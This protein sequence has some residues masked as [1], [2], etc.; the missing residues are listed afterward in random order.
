VQKEQLQN[1][2]SD[3]NREVQVPS[4]YTQINESTAVR[5]RQIAL[6]AGIDPDADREVIANMVAGYISNSARY[7]LTPYVTPEGEDFAL[8]FLETSKLG[9]CIHFTT[10]ATLMLRSLDIPAR[11][12]SGYVVT[13]SNEDIGNIITITDRNAHAW[14]E[15][16]YDNVGWIPLEVTP[17][18]S[19]SG[20]PAG[21][22]NISLPVFPQ[23]QEDRQPIVDIPPAQDNEQNPNRQTRP[24]TPSASDS[25]SES[26]E[27]VET[28][29]SGW[30]IIILIVVI[31]LCPIAISQYRRLLR[32]Y[33]MNRISHSD[34]NAA[35]IYFWRFISGLSRE[36]PPI[37]LE[38]I[39]L[40]ARFSQHRISEKER[41]MMIDGG[42]DYASG[43]YSKKKKPTQLWLKYIR[44]V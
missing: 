27:S 32:I 34:T 38:E 25:G 2:L 24:D 9:Y 33:R 26:Y 15:V 28:G 3:Y 21:I 23:M 18:S 12:T 41:E 22:P 44:G 30:S 4:V 6:E 31:V 43:L 39:A 29:K 35:V 8:Y 14:V 5:L 16:Y 7:T 40:K 37:E 42:T 1:N 36:K 19:G 13:V 11:Y 20:I 17:P 10:A